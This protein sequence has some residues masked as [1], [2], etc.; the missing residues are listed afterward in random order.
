ME[1]TGSLTT[2]I[3][4][5]K[6]LICSTRV[7]IAGTKRKSPQARNADYVIILIP[8]FP[9]KTTSNSIKREDLTAPEL[10]N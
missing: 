6:E 9:L 10:S 3:G 5:E 7:G 4:I 1:A 2:N 8:Q